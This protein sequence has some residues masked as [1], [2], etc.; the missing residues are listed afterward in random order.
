[1]DQSPLAQGPGA[2][3][4]QD[5]VVCW[6][7]RPEVGSRIW[8]LEASWSSGPEGTSESQ[9]SIWGLGLREGSRR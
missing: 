5:P 9:D 4:P 8:D 2:P 7:L 1:M 3:G 6:L